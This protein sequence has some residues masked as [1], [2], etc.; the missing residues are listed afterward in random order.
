LPA[1]TRS[2]P[3]CR[4]SCGGASRFSALPRLARSRR[5]S[6][7]SSR[8]GSPTPCSSSRLTSERAGACLARAGVPFETGVPRR[9]SPRGTSVRGD[10]GLDCR[11]RLCRL[12]DATRPL[13]VGARVLLSTRRP[14]RFRGRADPRPGPE[15]FTD[16][17]DPRA[18]DPRRH[19][20]V[21]LP[22]GVRSRC[23]SSCTDHLLSPDE[24]LLLWAR[25]GLHVPAARTWPAWLTRFTRV[26]LG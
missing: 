19:H 24:A 6:R 1:S 9:C 8:L 26:V 10:R 5:R 25:G 12:C 15:R 20:D 4:P 2:T 18:C 16:V 11:A 23:S 7:S 13:G 3:K 17:R 21:R 22:A 14:D